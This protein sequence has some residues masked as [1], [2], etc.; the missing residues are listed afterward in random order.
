LKDFNNRDVAGIRQ[1]LDEIKSALSGDIG[2]TVDLV[3]GG[4]VSRHTYLDGLSDVDALVLLEPDEIGQ[5][6]PESLKARFA[7]RLR[8]LFGN[9]NVKVGDLA[10]TVT[11]RGQE[12]QL[13]P[14]MREGDGYRIASP[15]GQSWSKINPKGFAEKLT[16]A[17][18]NLEGKLV[19]TIKLAKAL[20]ARLPKKQQLKG[21]HIESLAIEAFKTYVLIPTLIGRELPKLFGRGFGAGACRKRAG[22]RFRI[23]AIG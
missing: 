6:S 19:P 11:V 15:D 17:N 20:I 21:Y 18:K 2:G 12:I 14:A 4:S 13:L 22:T 3:F 5:T 9:E 23:R 8:E 10:V 7:R 1:I 16:Q